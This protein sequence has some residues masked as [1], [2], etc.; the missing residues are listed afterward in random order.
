M[1]RFEEC[2][3][4]KYHFQVLDNLRP[5]N[6]VNFLPKPPSVPAGLTA[7]KLTLILIWS[8]LWTLP[9]LGWHI[10]LIWPDILMHFLKFI[11][12]FWKLLMTSP[13]PHIKFL[14]PDSINLILSSKQIIGHFTQLWGCYCIQESYPEIRAGNIKLL[15]G[16]GD[17]MRSSQNKFRNF[18]KI[19]GVFTTSGIAWLDLEH[20]KICSHFCIK[21]PVFLNCNYKI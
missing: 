18:R 4:I 12:L 17:V 8:G 21:S 13:T 3:L 5:A 15:R 11:N 2:S 1:W 16:V 19:R 6:F 7:A 20:C 9:W 10:W 14:F